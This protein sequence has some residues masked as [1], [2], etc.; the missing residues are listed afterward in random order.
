MNWVP[1]F[2]GMTGVEGAVVFIL[3]LNGKGVR[4]AGG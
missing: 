1:A 2:A 3:S 4:E